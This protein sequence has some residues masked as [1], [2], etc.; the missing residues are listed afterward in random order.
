[1]AELQGENPPPHFRLTKGG[2]LSLSGQRAPEVGGQQGHLPPPPPVGWR[3]MPPWPYAENFPG[4]PDKDF[5]VSKATELAMGT[6]LHFLSEIEG[7]CARIGNFVMRFCYHPPPL[8]WAKKR[9]S[10]SL[11]PRAP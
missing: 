11:G 2:V 4:G 9:G 8:P 5:R 6:L 3:K 10:S 7:F 1:M